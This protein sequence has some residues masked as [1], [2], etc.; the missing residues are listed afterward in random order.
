MMEVWH[1]FILSKGSFTGKE[2]LMGVGFLQ[3]HRA[4][5]CFCWKPDRAGQPCLEGESQT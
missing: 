1:V 5:T 2:T 4:S 3:G